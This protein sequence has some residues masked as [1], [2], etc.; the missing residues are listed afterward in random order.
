M[1]GPQS[2]PRLSP[3]ARSR[4]RSRSPAAT[5]QR[6][7]D[8]G[9]PSR[10]PRAS[11]APAAGGSPSISSGRWFASSTRGS[12]GGGLIEQRGGSAAASPTTGGG[13]G[14]S[15]VLQPSPTGSPRSRS[16]GSRRRSRS[17][18]S[19]SSYIAAEKSGRASPDARRYTLGE[20]VDG[21]ASND[22][23][24]EF[25]RALVGVREEWL[26][27]RE[28]LTLAGQR[29]VRLRHTFPFARCAAARTA[30]CACCSDCWG[31]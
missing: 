17:P 18:R 2:P 10:L 14:V 11:A 26:A 31:A 5:V 30:R 12:R 21:F 15:L 4:S 23:D 13:G 20:S 7:R 27:L 6:W 24:P 3:R 22:Q 19:P 16:V 8:P 9:S 29:E 28:D 1:L 25:S